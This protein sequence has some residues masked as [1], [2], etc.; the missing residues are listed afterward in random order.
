MIIEWKQ[1]RVKILVNP[2][3]GFIHL[4]P[5]LNDIDDDLWKE[6]KKGLSTE[7]DNQW[8]REILKV[9]ETNVEGKKSKKDVTDFNSMGIEDCRKMMDECFNIKTLE[10]WRDNDA[11][12]DIR[13]NIDKRIETLLSD[14]S[15]K[16]II[17]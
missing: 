16:N 12:V 10:K 17:K 4:L 9:V 3:G 7:Y 2:N 6:M 5:G 11:R 8:I 15:A 14:T 13:V 1:Q